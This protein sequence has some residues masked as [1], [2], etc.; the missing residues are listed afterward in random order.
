MPLAAVAGGWD[1]QRTTSAARVA[2][3]GMPH[4]VSAELSRREQY[5]F[6]MLPA[7]FD[8]IVSLIVKTSTDLPPDVRAAM[9]VAMD[10]EEPADAVGAGAGHHRAEHRPGR[11]R[12]GRHLP[13]HRHA[14]LRGQDAGRR[15]P[16]RAEAADQ[17]GGGRGDASAASCGPTRS[18]RS[19]ARTRGNNLGPGTPIIHFEQWERDEIE[20]KLILKGGGCENMNAQY[21]LPMELP[22]L[23]RADRT[24]EGVRKCILHAVWNAQGKG[25]AP[26]ALGVCDRRRPHLGL[27]A[28]QGAAVPHARRREPRSAAGGARSRDH[29]RG[30]QA[31]HRHDGLR[32]P[33][34]AHRLQGRRR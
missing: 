27:R 8:S 32:R 12:R 31:G 15:Q 10:R 21:S 30:E 2:T 16:D 4:G 28:R 1:R 24:L 33:H 29:G 19:P 11:R 25:C 34:L 20:V 5:T 13:G 18:T 22:H 3:T 14:D 17:G 6:R 26:G 7:F 9:K 23:G